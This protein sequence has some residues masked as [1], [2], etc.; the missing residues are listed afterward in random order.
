MSEEEARVA[1]D[2]NRNVV[3]EGGDVRVRTTDET[4]DGLAI[5]GRVT[6]VVQKH[7]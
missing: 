2:L 3:S 4:F 6:V 7:E 5:V 1:C